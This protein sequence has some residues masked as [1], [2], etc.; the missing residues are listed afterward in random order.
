MTIF[1]TILDS[2]VIE[3][4]V[5]DQLKVWSRT[6]IEEVVQQK[7]LDAG[8]MPDIRTWTT[9]NEFVNFPEE[10]LPIVLVIGTGTADTP[11]K[12]GDGRIRA[13]WGIGI[14]VIAGGKDKP[15]SRRN[16]KLYSAAIRAAL[17]QTPRAETMPW[18]QGI[19]W[20]GE[21]PPSQPDDKERALHAVRSAFRLDVRGIVNPK[22]GPDQP[23]P[24]DP[25]VPYGD[26]PLAE[27]VE[28]TIT[29]EDD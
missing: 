5:V 2:D 19:D 24:N 1:D 28:A 16:A 20:E 14:A 13:H 15:T 7:G 6:Y 23:L 25:G 26:W 4:A 8:S 17:L 22:A 3:M 9:A 21:S 29:K 12:E 27:T 18:C 11:T 10:R